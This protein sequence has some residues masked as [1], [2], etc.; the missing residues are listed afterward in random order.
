MHSQE[1][2]ISGIVMLISTSSIATTV[3]QS[4]DY[5]IGVFAKEHRLCLSEDIPIH[6][7]HLLPV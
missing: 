4:S 6:P 1:S 7:H 2:L 5:E 3:I